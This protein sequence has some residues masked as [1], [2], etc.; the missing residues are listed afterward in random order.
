MS[1]T[2]ENH[3][4]S[5]GRPRRARRSISYSGN[6]NT[7]RE[8][9]ARCMVDIIKSKYLSESKDHR[10][11]RRAIYERNN[12]DR[13]RFSEKW[14]AWKKSDAGAKIRNNY[15]N[16]N[17]NNNS[18]TSNKGG[19]NSDGNKKHKKRKKTTIPEITYRNAHK[20]DS[21]IYRYIYILI[22]V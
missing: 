13:Q 2:D 16:D 18:D 17:N 14:N 8:L 7:P 5:E 9:F 11:Q 4:V 3:D 1:A 19:T 6:T 21:H 12:M 15:N 10:K 22:S 20:R